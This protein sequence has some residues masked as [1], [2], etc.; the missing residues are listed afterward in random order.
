MH[1]HLSESGNPPRFVFILI[2]TSCGLLSLLTLNLSF[3]KFEA[4]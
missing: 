4:F 1:F 3:T 2:Y